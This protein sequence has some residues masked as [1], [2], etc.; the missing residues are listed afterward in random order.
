MKNKWFFKNLHSFAFFIYAIALTLFATFSYRIMFHDTWEYISVAKKFAGYLNGDMFNVHSLV[1]PFFLSF[2]AKILPSML[3]L[4]LVNISW[5]FLIGILLYY[6]ESKKTAF[7]IWVFSPITWA[8][9][10]QIS[11]FLP[12]SFFLL[13]AF[14][15]IKKWQETK[16]RLYFVTSALSLGLSAAFYD[17]ALVLVVFF[18]LVFFYN[19]SLKE[20][21]FYCLV[22]LASFSTRLLLE[23]TLFSLAIKDKLI[24]FPIFSLVRF[25]GATLIIQLG[26]HPMIPI[27]KFSFSN[28]N[29]LFI[30]FIISPLLF[31][32]YKI[33]YK[34]HKQT[35]VFL[36]IS[37][38]FIL[39]SKGGEYFYYLSLAPIII[40]LLS[41]VF[42]RKELLL[43]AIISSFI[44][45]IIV[46]PY[47][48]PDKQ[49]I[50]K[51]N[52][53]IEDLKMINKDFSFDAVVLDTKT[54]ATFYIWDKHTPYIMASGDYNKIVQ[55]DTYYTHYTFEIK[56][57]ID[58][59]KILELQA[60]LKT[61]IKEGIDYKSLPWLLEKG[62][63]QPEGYELTKC[64]TLLCVYQKNKA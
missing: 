24:P 27:S 57:Q 3:T 10:L 29:L 64:Y 22:T 50:I 37:I 60:G 56:S 59:Q 40:L 54:L 5:L 9:G 13:V 28:P 52:L 53:T 55:N 43:H 33:D 15:S 58:T 34:K 4:K 36:L 7:L 45:I 8:L 11:P 18:V 26:L 30:L 39:L 31:Y 21:I 16:K 62:E 25:W 42:K 38:I 14:L 49:E 51:R 2:F 12:A 44:I 61:H 35:L 23:A 17:F 63:K 19:R 46:Y 47:F 48:I 41:E 6:S 20:T 32:L 1:Y